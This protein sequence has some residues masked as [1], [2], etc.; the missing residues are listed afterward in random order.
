M[1]YDLITAEKIKIYLR[2]HTF[3][4][5]IFAFWSVGS[6][7]EFAYKLANQGEQEGT[8]VIAEEQ[9]EGRG[10]MKRKWHSPFGKGLWFSVILRPSSRTANAGL[11]PYLAGVSVAQAIENKIGLRP[12]VK[13]PN[14]LLLNDK[15][16]CGIL[17]E[18]EFIDNRI[19]FI[20]LGIGINVNHKLA[21]FPEE[22]QHHATSLLIEARSK[23]DR[24][25]LLA[26]II[27]LLEQ[28]YYFTDEYGFDYITANWKK[29]CPHLGKNV[30]IIQDEMHY[31]GKFED[32]DEN[33]CLLLRTNSGDLQKIVAGDL[34]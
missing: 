29:R 17:S 7:N 3:G 8:I 23:I 2:T 27:Y 28:H 1:K 26:E 20:I 33:G 15:K 19:D 6:T 16:F 9:I 14:D 34:V 30:H 11:Y 5:K 22:L 12:V 13:W 10:R 25:Y 18:V 4:R 32:L 21:D 31:E 24:V